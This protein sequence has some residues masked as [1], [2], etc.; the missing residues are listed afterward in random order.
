MATIDDA[1]LKQLRIDAKVVETMRT[2]RA[3]GAY[4]FFTIPLNAA[5]LLVENMPA[6][7]VQEDTRAIRAAVQAALF[8]VGTPSIFGD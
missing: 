7:Y 1:E 8:P 3:H 6:K 4:V 2:A 5:H